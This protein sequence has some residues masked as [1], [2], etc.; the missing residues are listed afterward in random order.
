MQETHVENA[1]GNEP[2]EREPR[3]IEFDM[4]LKLL[5]P[6]DQFTLFRLKRKCIILTLKTEKERERWLWINF[7]IQEK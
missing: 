6:Q 2:L 3:E 5:P 4:Q 1:C 7:D